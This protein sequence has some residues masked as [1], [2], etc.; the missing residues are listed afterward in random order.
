[1]KN[2]LIATLLL[3]F[4]QGYAQIDTKSIGKFIRVYDVDG[5]KIAKGKIV[6]T[7]ENELQLSSS[8]IIKINQIGFIKT[9]HSGGHNV[10]VGALIG[11]GVLGTIGA[12]SAE[13]DSGW[14]SYT[15]G[16]GAAAGGILG[17]FTGSAVGLFSIIFKEP[18]TYI[19]N[20]D[21]AKWKEFLEMMT[22]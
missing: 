16:E 10:L 19:V 9:K 8:K 1:M 3:F 7:S 15:A 22:K 20:G 5:H 12:A 6:L 21:E 11:G 18:K 14:F 17:A 4:Y 13:P 2:L